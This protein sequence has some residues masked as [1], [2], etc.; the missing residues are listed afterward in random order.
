VATTTDEEG[1][2]SKERRRAA[3]ARRRGNPKQQPEETCDRLKRSL[4]VNDSKIWE[5]KTCPKGAATTQQT[6]Q[7]GAAKNLRLELG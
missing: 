5:R 2:T 7:E 1:D 6:E 4:G 3:L